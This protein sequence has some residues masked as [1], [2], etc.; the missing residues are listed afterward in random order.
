MRRRRLSILGKFVEKIIVPGGEGCWLWKGARDEYGY[1]VF[2][3]G[4]GR[5]GKAQRRAYELFVG[6][7]PEGMCVLHHCDVRHCVNPHHLFIG[8]R[9]DNVADMI[10]KGRNSRGEKHGGK[11]LHGER[12]LYSKL[13]SEDVVEI[14]KMRKAGMYLEDIANIFNVT[15]QN[16]WSIVNKKTWKHIKE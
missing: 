16:I 7:I 12:Q 13:T 14:L 2:W 9:A 8:T 10:S 4:K 15:R 11:V 5:Q 6:P 3:I 1:G